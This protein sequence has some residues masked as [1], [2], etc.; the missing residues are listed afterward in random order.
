[1]N[2]TRKW[3]LIAAAAS[4]LIAAVSYLVVI[5]PARAQAA[6]IDEQAQAQ[7]NTNQQLEVT[8]AQLRREATELQTQQARLKEL[9]M[10]IPDKVELSVLVRQIADSVRKTGAATTA[11]TPSEPQ[12]LSQTPAATPAAGAAPAVTPSALFLVPISVTVQGT[13]GQMEK[14]LKQFEAYQRVFL[15]TSTSIQP[16]KGENGQSTNTLSMTVTGRVF[17]RTNEFAAALDA[18]ANATTSGS[19]TSRQEGLG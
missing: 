14:T 17:T 19:V 9:N 15:I 12:Q 8:I 11:L 13:F 4:V 18:A 16:V 7:A 6:Q 10:R 5:S 1:M 2:P 3:A